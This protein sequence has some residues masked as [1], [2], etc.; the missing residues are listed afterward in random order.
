MT[1]DATRHYA[2]RIDAEADSWESSWLPGRLLTRN[3]AMTAMVL[4]ETVATS[5]LHS[6]DPKWAHVE[7]WAKELDLTGP[8][9]VVR[10]STPLENLQ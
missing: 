1:S 5:D 6:N 3:Q 2:T 8:D 4:A 9:A 10:A 7:N